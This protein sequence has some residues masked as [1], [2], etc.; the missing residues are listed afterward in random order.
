MTVFRVANCQITAAA[1]EEDSLKTILPMIA[2]ASGE[3]DLVCL[4]ECATMM[5]ADKSLIISDC[6]TEKNSLGLATLRDE[7]AARG[8]WIL[9]GSLTIRPDDEDGLLVNRSYL[10]A[11]D[12]S[13][14]ARYDKINMFDVEVGD[15]QIY[16]E[17]AFYRSGHKAVLAET[18]FGQIGM[19]ICYDVRFP[20]LFRHLAQNGAEIITVPAAFTQVTGLAHWHVLMR[21]R[22]IETGCFIVSP[23]QWGVH[24]GGRETYGHSLIVSPWGEIL[25]DGGEGEGI[26]YAEINTEKVTKARASIPSLS[27]DRDFLPS[28]TT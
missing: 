9:I 25:A 23:A 6:P 22:A 5:G 28:R 21:A 19:T 11:P 13:I 2:E 24:A 16:C 1:R 10:I 15:G 14:C 7:A 4:P 26:T 27:H 12:G 8:V 3:A 20:A 17:S 18:P